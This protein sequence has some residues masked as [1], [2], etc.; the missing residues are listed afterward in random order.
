MENG[1]VSGY[2]VQE[3]NP[4]DTN[5]WIPALQQHP[6][7]FGQA[8]RLAPADRGYFSAENEREAQA[9]GR[10]EGGPAGARASV[11]HSR[12]AAEAALV[13]T[14]AALAGWQ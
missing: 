12:S 13:P 2:K 6:A 10:G 14:G 9:R 5:A 4:A 11:A 3:G 7:L 1:I 8:P